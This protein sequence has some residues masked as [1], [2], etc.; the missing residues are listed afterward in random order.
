MIVLA[1]IVGILTVAAP[2]LFS[3]STQMRA[4]IRKLAV[5]SRE[6]RNNARMY[7]MTTRLVID[8][9]KEGAHSYVVESSDGDVTLLSEEQQKELD[10]LTEIQREG[11]K[12]KTSFSIES[13]VTRSA[14]ALPRGLF[15]ESV[16]LASREQ[17][18]TEGKAYIHFFSKGFSEDAA[19][20]LTDRKTL[21]WTILINPLTGRAEVFERK[22]SLKEIRGQ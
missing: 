12:P 13:R 19:L 15:F 8:M 17:P 20:H 7:N 11:E 9:K 4:A 2:R 1:I 10:R 3:T 5:I 6:V 22:I 14:V 16:E 18:V 21:N